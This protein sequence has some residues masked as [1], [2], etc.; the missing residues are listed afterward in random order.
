MYCTSILFRSLRL[1]MFPNPFRFLGY[2]APRAKTRTNELDATTA[3]RDH[4]VRIFVVDDSATARAALK[5]AL[6][7]RGDWVVVGEAVDGHHALATFHLHTPHLTL[8]DFIMSK[9]NGLDTARHLT[10][11]HPDILILMVT[12]DP[13]SQLEKEAQSVGIKGLCPKTDMR[14]LLNAV[15]AVLGGGTYFSEE[16]VA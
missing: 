5:S 4:L 8:M 7:G 1:Q 14:C 13:S 15:E 3:K 12:T 11:R 2:C 10:A 16:A 6:E 9:M